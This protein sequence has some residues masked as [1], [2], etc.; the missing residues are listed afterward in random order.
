MLNLHR[1]VMLTKAQTG[2]GVGPILIA[3]LVRKLVAAVAV[4]STKGLFDDLPQHYQVNL[5]LTREGDRQR[6]PLAAQP[7]GD[8]NTPFTR[9]GHAP[10]LCV[11]C[12]LL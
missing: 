10:V 1:L 2:E 5:V 3:C 4:R 12:S 9:A 7:F 11:V 6:T 8:V